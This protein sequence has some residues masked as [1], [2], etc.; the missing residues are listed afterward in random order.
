LGAKLSQEKEEFK[1]IIGRKEE[2]LKSNKE[3]NIFLR[4]QLLRL[5]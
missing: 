3:E 2:V 4:E 5:G 1:K